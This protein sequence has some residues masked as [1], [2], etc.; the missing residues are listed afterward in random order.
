MTRDGCEGTSSP[1]RPGC[2][3]LTDRD[4]LFGGASQLAS[5][6]GPS[7]APRWG[8]DLSAISQGPTVTKSRCAIWRLFFFCFFSVQPA[9]VLATLTFLELFVTSWLGPRGSIWTGP[10]RGRRKQN[11]RVCFLPCE[12]QWS[13]TDGGVAPHY[14]LPDADKCPPPAPSPRLTLH[15]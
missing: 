8:R 4:A 12:N 7:A 2:R 6:L 14:L 10:I 3:R 1:L 9:A 5:D 13:R 15:R 11:V